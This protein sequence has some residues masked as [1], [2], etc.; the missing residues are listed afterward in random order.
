VLVDDLDRRPPGDLDALAALPGAGTRVIAAVGT[1]S[2][3]AAHRPPLSDW[4]G[5]PLVV[6]RPDLPMSG[7]VVAGG[8]GP[9]ADPLAATV[10]GRAVLVVDGRA[11]PVQLP[12]AGGQPPAGPR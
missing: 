1:Q 12:V 11:L 2:A 10:P 4:L 6:L 3:L 5:G 9:S 8:I 7:R